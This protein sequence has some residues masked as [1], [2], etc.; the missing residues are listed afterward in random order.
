MSSTKILTLTT[1]PPNPNGSTP[2]ERLPTVRVTNGNSTSSPSNNEAETTRSRE[3]SADLDPTI[4]DT[5]TGYRNNLRNFTFGTP[6]PNLDNRN[7]RYNHIRHGDRSDGS[8]QDE[9]GH[10]TTESNT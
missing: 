7:H 1:T 4:L 3:T 8:D 10:D 9:N 6:R 5:G 2:A